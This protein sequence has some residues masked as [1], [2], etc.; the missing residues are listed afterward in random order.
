MAA[1]I[2]GYVA[3]FELREAMVYC[4]LNWL[5]WLSVPAD[6][7]AKCVAQ[8]RLHYL[9]E[10]HSSDAARAQATRKKGD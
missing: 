8:Y 10:A 1:D 7:R 2:P 6:E 4:N 3:E 9:V 5:Q